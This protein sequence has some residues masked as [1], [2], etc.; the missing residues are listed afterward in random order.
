MIKNGGGRIVS[1]DSV[2]AFQAMVFSLAYNTAK[3]GPATLRRA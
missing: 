3:D 1:V 2:S